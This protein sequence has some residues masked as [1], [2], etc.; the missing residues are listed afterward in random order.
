[1]YDI[2]II[3]GG[4]VGAATAYYLSKFK[5][6]TLLLES[7]SD[8]C[9]GASKANSGIVHGGYDPKPGSLMAK[10][11][12]RGN[13]LI[14]ECSKEL[15]FPYKKIGSLVLAFGEEDDKKIEELYKRGLEN[16]IEGLSILSKEQTLKKEPLANG[17]VT[18][19][20]H[21]ENSGVVSPWGMVYAFGDNAAS[22][23]V[24]I[25]LDS[26]V[27]RI[28]KESEIFSVFC[29]DTEYRGKYIVNAA[30]IHTGEIAKM[31]G[32]DSININAYA[33]QYHLLDKGALF[34]SKV[35]FPAPSDAGKGIL[36]SPTAGGNT[37]AGPTSIK[38]DFEDTAT[39]KKTLDLIEVAAKKSIPSIDFNQTIRTFSGL[40]AKAEYDDFI[41]EFSKNCENLLNLAGIK[42]PGLTAAPAIGEMAAE[43]LIKRIGDVAKKEDYK[44]FKPKPLFRTLSPEDKK[45]IAV[46][47]FSY[48]QIIC[49][50]ETV[51]KGDIEAALNR[52]V[53]VSTLEGVK[54]RCNAGMGRCQS[55]FCSP[56]VIEIIAD[57][58]GISPLDVRL[59]NDKSYILTE[60]RRDI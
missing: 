19:S 15:A 42:S 17:E 37:L 1:M 14:E 49:R 39:D 33:G 7:G 4:A 34:L 50:C 29:K 45:S 52:P 27:T 48:A 32:D 59:E 9:T 8:L 2:I 3:G 60:D 41:V 46:K 6:K 57:I 53:R 24:S 13:R 31:A 25:K 35:V 56:K 23:G 20:L 11:N 40:R 36:V 43:M 38:T 44:I 26:K 5:L 12:L 10:L 28:E 21:C 22:N 54:R 18:S 55:G 51:T 16:G 30:G 58:R 47:D